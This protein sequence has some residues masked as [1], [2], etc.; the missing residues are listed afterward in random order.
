MRVSTNA[1]DRDPPQLKVTST[2]PKG[3]RVK[4]GD[5]ITVTI[6][7]S[8]RY[9][10]GHKSR[11]TGVQIIQLISDTDGLIDSKQFG[12]PPDPCAR[13]SVVMKPYLVKK[14]L[15]P[16]IHLHA[17]A[18]DAVGHQGGDDGDFPTIGDYFGTLVFTS[19]QNVPSGVQYF[20]GRF[21]VTLKR[22]GKGNLTGNLSGTQSE[23]LDI[24]KCPSDTTTPGKVTAK[25]N[26]VLKG[27]MISL[28]ASDGTATP[29]IMIPCFGRQ[30]GKPPAVYMW[31]HFSQIFHNLDS[32]KDGTYRFDREW[33]NSGGGH[34]YTERYTLKLMRAK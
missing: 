27:K 8:E 13:Q 4:A 34:P 18:E 24:A 30:P 10:D 9:A 17:L 32:D 21:D 3:T 33:T 31:P 20:K 15:P 5:T 23:K 25:L 28:D 1:D 29:P 14:P 19:H 16:I 7:A 12:H 11:P 6:K 26:G 22:D 2:P